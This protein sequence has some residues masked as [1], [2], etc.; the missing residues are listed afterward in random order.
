MPCP[1]GYG[2]GDRTGESNWIQKG[3]KLFFWG[4]PSDWPLVC[5]GEDTGSCTGSWTLNHLLPAG[6]SLPLPDMPH[7]LM[8]K[9]NIIMKLW[10]RVA[11]KIKSVNAC[12]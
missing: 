4:L 1:L 7:F 12:K 9:I 2:S 3:L 8:C 5:I 10:H 11:V 6:F